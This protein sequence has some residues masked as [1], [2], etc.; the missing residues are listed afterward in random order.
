[1]KNPVVN[2]LMTLLIIGLI[3][4]CLSGQQCASDRLN[5]EF[6]GRSQSSSYAVYGTIY[7]ENGMG[8]ANVSIQCN[9]TIQTAT[10]SQGNWSLNNLQGPVTITPIKNDWLFESST[11]ELAHSSI[12]YTD[13]DFVGY[14]RPIY[15]DTSAAP[16]LI[17]NWYAGQPNGPIKLNADSSGHIQACTAFGLDDNGYLNQEMAITFANRQRDPIYAPCPGTITHLIEWDD[18]TT[19]FGSDNGGE[20]WIRYG[21]NFAVGFRHIVTQG[22]NLSPGLT[23]NQGDII[24]YTADVVDSEGSFFEFLLAQQHDDQ[25][26]YLNPYH[27]FDPLSREYLLRIWNATQRTDLP[28]YA[29]ISQPW[30]D[31]DKFGSEAGNREIPIKGGFE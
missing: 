28:G 30:G 12:S 16:Q 7:D 9:G 22:L 14:Y 24:G 21:R 3:L 2:P 1:M 23:V 19:A 13:I 27:Y 15:P 18:F 5:P 17:F 4:S 20:I 26:Y 6:W 25:Y 10:D 29:G 8:I 31:L 11:V